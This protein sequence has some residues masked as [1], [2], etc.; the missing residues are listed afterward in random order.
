MLQEGASVSKAPMFDGT[1]FVFYKIKMETYLCSID[2]DVWSIVLN[3]YDVP[4]TISTDCD[5]KKE[6]EINAR[7]KHAILCGITK[8]LFVK[9]MHCKSAK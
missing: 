5:E 3:G 8:D 7:A 4:S 6:Y 9:V 2:L 1:D